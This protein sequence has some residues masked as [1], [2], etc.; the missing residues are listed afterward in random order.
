[1]IS[2]ISSGIREGGYLGVWV[3]MTLESMV[4][5]VPSELVMPFAGFL[6]VTGEFTLTG[7]AI[8]STLGSITGSV[9][10]YYM[11]RIG[12]R[13]LVLRAGKYLL[14]HEGHLAQTERFF[15]RYG[16]KAI[17]FARLVP[18]VRHLIS[19]PAGVGK[20]KM[21]KFLV[22]TVAGAAIWNMFLAW[23]GMMLR[24]RW[25]VIHEYTRILD[26]VVVAA[27]VIIVVYF[28]VRHRARATTK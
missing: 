8:A 14:L 27:G 4:A 6:I 13:P 12:G 9:V 10:S 22:Y 20:M 1:L 7:I 21:G 18:V 25:E 26:Y 5:P 23:L 3:L 16:E 17:F 28:F 15:E 24:E 11:G 19:I 2:V